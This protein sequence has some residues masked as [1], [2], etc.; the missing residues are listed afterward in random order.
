V[1]PV[2]AAQIAILLADA[3]AS[4]RR[5][6]H[7]LLHAGHD[8]QVQRL[9]IALEPGSYVR[10]HQHSQQWEML[11][12]NRGRLDM[13][14]FDEDGILLARHRLDPSNPVIQIPV[15]TWHAGL[16]QESGT[17]VMEVKPGPYRPNEFAD[18][19]PEENT[20]AAAQLVHWLEAAPAGS[21]WA[22]A[23]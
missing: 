6:A 16:A 18:W 17:V 15:G 9:L 5:R 14:A 23:G 20:P 2:T 1:N 22:P 21:R 3:K 11:V 8:D 10:P 13:L 19:A 12:L 4:P 7:L